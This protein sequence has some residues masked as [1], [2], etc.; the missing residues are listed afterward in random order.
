MPKHELR[1]NGCR[2]AVVFDAQGRIRKFTALQ[3]VP[4]AAGKEEEFSL[5]DYRDVEL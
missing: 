4:R 1:R 2:E 5:L 3:H